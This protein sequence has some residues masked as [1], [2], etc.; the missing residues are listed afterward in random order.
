M[1]EFSI[2]HLVWGPLGAEPLRSFLESLRTHPAGRS[3]ELVVIF[4]GLEDRE[5]RHR[6]EAELQSVPHRLV[7]TDEPVID[8]SAYRFA[9]DSIETP[10]VLFVNSYTRVLADNWLELM[11]AQ[12]DRDGVGM[13]GATGT[14]E[15]IHSAPF[16]LRMAWTK[17]FPKFPNY[18]LRTTGFAL[19]T[20]LA[21]QLRWRR[22]SGKISALG[23]ESGRRSISRE[24]KRR[25]LELV[26]AGA[27]GRGYGEREW[28]MSRTFRDGEQENLLLADNRTDDYA[29]ADAD[30]RA[31]LRALAWGAQER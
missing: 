26:V 29:A 20:E 2:V 14:W 4:N 31:R 30:A 8:L 1:N 19:D 3:Y 18:H 24:V 28:S 11:A 15:S 10:R 21:R 23:L 27:D 22:P 5:L 25:G 7:E 12:L 6:L 16:K 17:L 13:V 9:L